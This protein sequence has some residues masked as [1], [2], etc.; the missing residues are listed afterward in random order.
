ML[1]L[2]DLATKYLLRERLQGRKHAVL[3]AS[4]ASAEGVE[5]RRVADVLVRVPVPQ[6][7]EVVEER[8]PDQDLVLQQRDDGREDLLERRGW[9]QLV[10][11]APVAMLGYVPPSRSFA[12]IPLSVRQLGTLL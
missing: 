11:R 5:Q 1:S 2:L 12:R 4:H 9:G 7:L 8:V 10:P 3:R 6:C